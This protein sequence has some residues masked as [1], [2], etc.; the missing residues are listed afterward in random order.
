MYKDM[1]YRTRVCLD[2][3]V[4]R[5]NTQ[6]YGVGSQQLYGNSVIPNARNE[7]VG[8]FLKSPADYLMWLDSDM[9][10]PD[11]VVEELFVMDKDIAGAI[12]VRKVPPHYPVIIN[13]D[14]SGVPHG[15]M[16]FPEEDYFKVDGIGMGCTLVKRKVF[17][18]MKPPYFAMPRNETLGRTE[19]ED[20]DFCNQAQKLGF[21][22][23]ANQ[24]VSKWVGHVGSFP[25]T[26]QDYYLHRE[27]AKE[28]GINLMGQMLPVDTHEDFMRGYIHRE[29]ETV[30]AKI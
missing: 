21:E 1:H 24:K 12:Y 11:T 9:T 6:N 23:W 3:V 18:A 10:F 30:D 13:K 17:E 29:L 26:V 2:A 14:E 28:Y 22:V 20:L 7:I 19:G 4:R 16:V 25:F 27:R 5:L 15:I 8:Y